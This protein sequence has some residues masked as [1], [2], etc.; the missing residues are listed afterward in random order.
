MDSN[1]GGIVI[2]LDGRVVSE[3]ADTNLHND[4]NADHASSPKALIVPPPRFTT[5]QIRIRKLIALIPMV[6]GLLSFLGSSYI[7]YSL[8]AT[9]VGRAKKLQTTFN[10]LLLA[11]S[12]SDMI[13]SFA[14]CLSQW[15]FPKEAFPGIDPEW[16]GFTFPYASGTNGSCSF[17]VRPSSLVALQREMLVKMMPI[18]LSPTLSI[19]YGVTVTD[20]TG[21]SYSAWIPWKRYIYGLHFDTICSSCE[22]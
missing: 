9:K 5:S 7:V 2:H 14:T 21:I 3:N 18:L 20:D 12:I 4:R 10:R 6:T 15:V 22:V 16:H 1:I 8:V 17:Q 13:S 11:L 19:V